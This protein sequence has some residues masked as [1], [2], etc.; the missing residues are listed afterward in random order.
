MYNGEKYDARKAL[1]TGVATMA[2]YASPVTKVYPT[3]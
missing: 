3:T 2:K 1:D